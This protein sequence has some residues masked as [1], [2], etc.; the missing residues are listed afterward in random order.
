MSPRWKV[1]HPRKFKMVGAGPSNSHIPSF[2]ES[3]K[4]EGDWPSHLGPRLLQISPPSHKVDAAPF[5]DCVHHSLRF[6]LSQHL[7]PRSL[8]IFLFSCSSSTPLLPLTLPS[9][10]RSNT[11]WHLPLQ[12]TAGSAMPTTSAGS[13]WD[14]ACAACLALLAGFP[15]PLPLFS[16][17]PTLPLTNFSKA[18]G[19]PRTLRV[20]CRLGDTHRW[21]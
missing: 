11:F 6:P 20:H 13:A 16:I 10:L 21:S 19:I 5:P 4:G 9:P 18:I 3:R 17:L 2:S 14:G 15:L 8:R 7:I 12:L 1:D